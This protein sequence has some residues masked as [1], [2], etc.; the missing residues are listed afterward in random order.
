MRWPC[1][2][3]RPTPRLP[4]RQRRPRRHL[5]PR[6]RGTPPGDRRHRDPPRGRPQQG[7]DQHHAFTQDAMD[8]RGI[9]D[10]LDVARFTPG[11]NIDNSRHQQHRHSRHRLHRRRRHHRHL[12]RR[13][14]DSDARPRLQPGR[15]AA[16][17]LRP[18]ARRGAARTAGHVVRRRLRGRHGALHHH[19][20]E[21]DPDQHLQ[22][23]TR[24]PTPKA[25]NR[26]TRRASPAAR[27]SSTAS[28]A[29]VSRLV[30]L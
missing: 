19:A 22:P 4:T 24:F 8:V 3:A 25:G 14:A 20:A 16:A 13:H 26:A 29:C 9:K 15:S 6:K 17:I 11:I 5:R 27:R 30:P 12:S 10:I 1:C 7:A 28:S 2:S 23:Q 18:R 21:P